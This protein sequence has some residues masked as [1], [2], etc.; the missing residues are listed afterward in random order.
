MST[1]RKLYLLI[2]TA[3]FL[4]IACNLPFMAQQTGTATP[5]L[6]ATDIAQTV[7]AQLRTATEAPPAAQTTVP[8]APT[9]TATDTPAPQPTDTPTQTQHPCNQAVFIS[10]VTI[11]DGSDIQTG[12]SFTKTWRLQNTGS[13]T[14]TSGYHVVFVNGDRMNSPDAVSVTGG[15]V[16]T[17]GTVDVSVTLT[18][19]AAPGTY[20]G[21]YRLRSSD[22]VVFGV[23][24]GVSFYVEIDAV[25]PEAAEE[26][27]EEE[28]EP[29]VEAKPDLIINGLTLNPAI[30]TKGDPVTVT[31]NTRNVGNKAS[32]AYT[33]YWYAGENYPA[34]ACTWNV[35]NSN[36]NGG[37]VLNCVYA[38]YPSWYPSLWTKA[39]IDPADNV[40]E[41]NEGNNSLRKEIKVNP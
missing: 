39:V 22:G 28:E 8:A 34:P 41:S 33:V 38:G 36:P 2:I 6:N 4:S 32:G 16:P 10:D 14:W 35:D 30:P 31:V 21:N 24:G 25:A 37:R 19:P 3:L 29:V 5:A 7:I 23:G 18:A 9:A 13:C 11:P 26:P 15:T 27:E 12:T 17:G 20:R 40:D 1:S